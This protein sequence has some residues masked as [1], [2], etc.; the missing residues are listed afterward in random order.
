MLARSDI[1]VGD[2]I[3]AFAEHGISAAYLVPTPTGLKKS[4]LDAHEGI[5]TFLKSQGIHE[6]DTQGQGQTNKVVLPI[7]LVETD[8][9]TTT[10]VSLYRPETKSGDPR[11]WISGLGKYAS[12]W[13][14]IAILTGASGELFAVNCSDA[15]IFATLANADS[16]LGRLVRS[17]PTNPVANELREKLE[18]IQEL[19]FIQSQ[20]S[21][22][23]GV[24]FTLESLL[25]IAANTKRTPDYKGIELKSGR[26]KS[27]TAKGGQLSTL[28]SK[29]PDKSR[30]SLNAK[31]TLATFGY[32]QE[33]RL[34]LYCTVGPK[35][36]TL[37]LHS[38]LT[39]LSDDYEIHGTPSGA[40]QSI[41]VN[42]WD[43]ATLEARLMAKHPET[44]W[45]DAL[46]KR[47]ATGVESF[48]YVRATH[49]QKPLVGNLATLLELGTVTMDYTL[50]ER[51]N[52]T[53]RD[54]GYLFRMKPQ[55]RGMLFPSPAVYVL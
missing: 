11:L 40:A 12:A 42:T 47:D 25:G 37:G 26:R 17:K 39:N 19:G 22:P 46:T 3:R 34:Q 7:T 43:T 51:P 9:I 8:S 1:P 48:H 24:G 49:T 45:V 55:D 30:S 29:S 2:A 53:I 41:P 52:G 10:T 23:T 18:A 33:G 35:P 38:C 20:R 54:H 31:A 32:V 27:V 4:I 13:N 28:F 16:P 15:S 21:G 5:R 14:L 50:S 6:F 44:F 36:N